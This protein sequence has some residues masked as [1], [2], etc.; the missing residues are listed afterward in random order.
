MKNAGQKSIRIFIVPSLILCI[1]SLIY[2]QPKITG[3]VRNDAVILSKNKTGHFSDILENRFIIKN[4][5]KNWKFYLDARVYLYFGEITEQLG[6]IDGDLMR[7]FI[8]YYADWADF[9]LGKTYIN[10]GNSGIFNP[11]EIDKTLNFSDISYAKRGILAFES[12]IPMGDL[13][14]T[15]IYAGYNDTLKNYSTGFDLIFNIQSFDLGMA[16]IKNGKNKNEKNII[17]TVEFGEE[18][19]NLAGFYFKGDMLLG[20]EASYAHHFN[21]KGKNDFIEANFGFDYSFFDAM[22]ILNTIFYYNENGKINPDNYLMQNEAYFF[23]KYYNYSGLIYAY[24][25]F[26]SFD[27]GVFSNLN[28]KSSIIIASVRNTIAN[29]LTLILMGAFLTG[30]NNDEYSR[31]QIG[32]YYALARVEGRY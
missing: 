30:K 20:V 5:S 22:F 13:S 15:K 27:L 11:F 26:L 4:D 10:L 16:A 2:A 18:S 21:D 9:T 29:G 24:D 32:E 12:V 3:V 25:E 1:F 8:R 23:A 6:E 28:D 7:S 17:N 31:R 14:R 19:R